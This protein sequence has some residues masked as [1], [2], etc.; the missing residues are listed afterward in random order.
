MSDT[1]NVS[2][3]EQEISPTNLPELPYPYKPG[4]AEYSHFEDPTSIYYGISPDFRPTTARPIPSARCSRIKKDGTR[5]GAYSVRGLGVTPHG[6]PPLCKVH[7]GSLPNFV[8]HS[9][10]V[11]EAARL[12]LTDSTPDAIATILEL[13][14]AGTTPE[15][16]RL[17]AATEI[18][19]RNNIKGTTDINIE[20]TQGEAPSVKLMK[21]LED[22]RKKE[23]PVLEDLGEAVAEEG[24]S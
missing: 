1:E 3:P 17:K 11:V 15:A 10:A 21:K 8:K 18:L 9:Q 13:M 7:G 23:E 12:Q 22:M 20:V 4:D 2:Y 6:P 24:E 16:V 19:D 14:K 5:C